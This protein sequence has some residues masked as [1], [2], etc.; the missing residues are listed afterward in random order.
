M[1]FA[2]L[3]DFPTGQLLVQVEDSEELEEC[4]FQ[5]VLKTKHESGV[6][7]EL[8]HGYKDEELRDKQFQEFGYEKAKSCF[9]AQQRLLY[10]A[11]G[12]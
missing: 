10:Q 3:F 11:V 12:E 5:I 2:K 7:L 4:E 8:K 9:D 6:T 1:Q